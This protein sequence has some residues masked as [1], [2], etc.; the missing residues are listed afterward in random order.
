MMSMVTS[1]EF[2]FDNCYITSSGWK[3]LTVSFMERCDHIF[4]SFMERCKHIFCLIIYGKF[5][6]IFYWK[7]NKHFKRKIHLLCSRSLY[8][9][10]SAAYRI[11]WLYFLLLPRGKTSKKRGGAV[12]N[13]KLNLMMALKRWS[14]GELRV[15]LHYNYSQVHSNPEWY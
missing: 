9:T 7:S 6:H 12:Y 1:I 2:F 10:L 3:H 13:L 15:H 4:Y 14:S 11:R 8:A 5:K